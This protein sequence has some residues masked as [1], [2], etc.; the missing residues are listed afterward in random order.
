MRDIK[1]VVLAEL[2]ESELTT[3]EKLERLQTKFNKLLDYLENWASNGDLNMNDVKTF[4]N[5]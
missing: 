3:E 4:I 5:A 1:S 2:E